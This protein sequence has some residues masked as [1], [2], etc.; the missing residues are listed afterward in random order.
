ML[1]L[2]EGYT[3]SY[4]HFEYLFVTYHIQKIFE[5]KKIFGILMLYKGV[6]Q[7]FWENNF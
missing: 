3:L 7:E 5:E 4:F 6:K 1:V 2:A